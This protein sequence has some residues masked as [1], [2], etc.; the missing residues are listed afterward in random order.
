[1]FSEETEGAYEIGVNLLQEVLTPTQL[2]SAAT[3]GYI[4]VASEMRGKGY[5]EVLLVRGT[6]TLL[7][8]GALLVRGDTHVDN[9]PMAKSLSE[10]WISAICDAT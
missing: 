2:P 9:R 7:K 5:G 4:G 3:I 6:T 8:S 10:R 1:M